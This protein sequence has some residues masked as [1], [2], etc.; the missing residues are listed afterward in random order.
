MID[1]MRGLL[2]APEIV[3]A[4]GGRYDRKSTGSR[5]RT[6]RP[7]LEEFDAVWEELFPAEQARIVQLL[8]ERVDVKP[9][10]IGI[11]LRAAGLVPW[12][13]ISA[14]PPRHGGLRDGGSAEQTETVTVHIPMVF[15]RA[16]GASW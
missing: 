16:R 1:Q 5:R 12:S 15:R 6:S 8:V 10:G 7:R 4:T 9:D 13:P 14:P 2:R 3:V 11:R